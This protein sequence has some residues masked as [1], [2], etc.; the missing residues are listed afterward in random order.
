MCELRRRVRR[1]LRPRDVLLRGAA[2][3]RRRGLRLRWRVRRSLRLLD[4]PWLR[5]CAGSR[6][7]I[8]AAVTATLLA[9]LRPGCLLL[10]LLMELTSADSGRDLRRLTSIEVRGCYCGW[11]LSCVCCGCGGLLI[12][13]RVRRAARYEAG[14]RDRRC[15]S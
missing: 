6:H 1:S 15:C 5:R 3:T 9:V 11:E 2:A 10:L 7:W 14:S 13:R 12:L 8:P 4:A